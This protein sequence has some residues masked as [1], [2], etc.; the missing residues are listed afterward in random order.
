MCAKI[1]DLLRA[2]GCDETRGEYVFRNGR[3]G[4]SIS[5][6]KTAFTNARRAAGIDNLTFHDLRHTWSTRAAECGVPDSVRRDVLGHSPATMTDSYT[7]TSP[8]A[9]EMAM[10]L[11]VG[12]SRE[13]I[14]SITAKLRQAG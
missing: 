7:H 11:G 8:E 5:D 10:E 4:F 9:M 1:R 14:F 6:I 3:T 12:Y 2:Y 13:K